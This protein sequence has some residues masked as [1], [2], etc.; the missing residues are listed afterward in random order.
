MDYVFYIFVPK[1][2]NIQSPAAQNPFNSKTS[3]QDSSVKKW[4]KDCFKVSAICPFQETFW[5]FFPRNLSIEKQGDRIE[6]IFEYSAIVVFG[7][8]F[9][10]KVDK[11][12]VLFFLRFNSGITF[13]KK[14]GSMLWSQFSSKNYVFLKNQC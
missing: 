8:F 13:D 14:L 1:Y 3:K 7:Q 9:I 10:T 2:W 4:I 12:F 11:F 6:H 5:I